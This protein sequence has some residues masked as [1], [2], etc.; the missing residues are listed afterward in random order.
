MFWGVQVR[1]TATPLGIKIM[2][3]FTFPKNKELEVGSYREGPLK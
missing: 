1:V 3:L 2:N